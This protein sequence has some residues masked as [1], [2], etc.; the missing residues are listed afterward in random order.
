MN[1]INLAIQFYNSLFFSVVKFFIG[2]YVIVLVVDLVLLL[3]Q[4]GLG[5]DLRETVL[6]IN[7]PR[8]LAS[9]GGKKKLVKKW[10]KLKSR[11]D[12]GQESQYKVAIIEADDLIDNLIMRMGYAG[13]NMADRLDGIPTGQ[14]E[15]LEELKQAHQVRNRIIHEDKFVLDRKTAEDTLALYE[16][17]LNYFHVFGD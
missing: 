12:T 5:S 4:R 10:G 16:I 9:K 11:L 15:Y 2:V 17:F 8:E 1:I 3:M 13:E 6:G 7:I 14:L